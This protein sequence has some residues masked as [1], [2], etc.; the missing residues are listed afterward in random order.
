MQVLSIIVGL[1]ASILLKVPSFS[2]ST[3][4]FGGKALKNIDNS[5]T[6]VISY[7]TSYEN[8]DIRKYIKCVLY[9]MF[10]LNK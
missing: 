9:T 2:Y 5:I 3:C 7:V 4:I 6:S 1:D 10:I 8:L